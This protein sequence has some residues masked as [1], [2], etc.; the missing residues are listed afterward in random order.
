MYMFICIKN[1][2]AEDK[3]IEFS[4]Q[5]KGAYRAGFKHRLPRLQPMRP[6]H[7]TYLCPDE[8]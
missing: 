6:H 7:C 4:L 3:L 8:K 1:K 2:K 5:K